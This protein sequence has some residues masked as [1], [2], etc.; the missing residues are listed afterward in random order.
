MRE[1]IDSAAG[2]D[3]RHEESLMRLHG[4]PVAGIDEAGRGPW[5]G[6][7]V[8]AAVILAPES[9]PDGLND[10]KKLSEERREALFARIMADA[11]VGIGIAGI[12][13]IDRMNI[14]QA[15]LSA[16]AAACTSLSSRPTAALIDGNRC[17]GS[18]PCPAQTLIRGDNLSLSVAAASIVAKVTRDRIMKGLAE[19]YPH[20]G[21]ARNKGY[22][23]REH[24][25]ALS[26]HGVTP[27]HRR[28]FRPVQD[29]LSGHRKTG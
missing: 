27:H 22:G 18:L 16:M 9:I 12:E 4:G 14:L 13:Q 5:A 20:Y 28:S 1:L 19:K 11:I 7:V 23:T 6:P 15:T 3:F 17:P 26:R 8:A 21:W 25:Q 29:I 24:S 10:S 2:P